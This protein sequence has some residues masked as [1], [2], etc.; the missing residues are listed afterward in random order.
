MPLP[1][2]WTSAPDLT[3]V[4]T[5][6]DSMRTIERSI[7]AIRAVARRV[8]VVD[9]G[10]TDGTVERCRGLGCEVFHRDWRGFAESGSLAALKQHGLDLADSTGWVLLLDSDEIPTEQ[11]VDSIIDAVREDDPSVDGYSLPR[12]HWYKGGWIRAE[13]RDRVVRLVRRGRARVQPRL[14]H[15]LLECR[16][17]TARLPGAGVL[18]HES[19]TDF[20]DALER[21]IRYAHASA[22]MPESRTS[23]AR[24]LLSPPWAF[25][26]TWILDRACLDGWRGL[27]ASIALAARSLVKHLLVRERDAARREAPVPEVAP[28]PRATA[29]PVL[30]ETTPLRSTHGP[31]RRAEPAGTSRAG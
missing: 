21:S 9:S 7:R 6:K 16:G 19:W 20:R 24:I 12:R 5:A 1:P 11:L 18:R 25:L 26:R 28:A 10:S 14:V 4:Y 27:E 15:E 17:R 2:T 23:V 3:V 29:P 30:I 13:R 31:E 8:I 22:L